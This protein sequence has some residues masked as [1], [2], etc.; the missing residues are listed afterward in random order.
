[1]PKKKPAIDKDAQLA[2]EAAMA[3]NKTRRVEFATSATRINNASS[4]NH[5][6]TGDG[7]LFVFVREGALDYKKCPSRG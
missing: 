7:D 5:Y 2:K 6:R 1:M 3:F 4:R